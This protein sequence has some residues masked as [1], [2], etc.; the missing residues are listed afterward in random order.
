MHAH[1][2]YISGRGELLRVFKLGTFIDAWLKRF[3]SPLVKKAMHV[4]AYC[5]FLSPRHH[6][7]SKHS[8]CFSAVL[9]RYL[10]SPHWEK[11]SEQ[12]GAARLCV[13]CE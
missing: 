6:L 10:R 13:P 2:I 4:G 8:I 9:A 11:H 3:A 7:K 12:L 5:A 1:E